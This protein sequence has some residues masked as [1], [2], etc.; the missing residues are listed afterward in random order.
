MTSVDRTL[1]L[2]AIAATTVGF[3][4]AALADCGSLPGHDALAKALQEAVKPSGGPRQ[5]RT[6]PQHVGELVDVDGAVCAV[7]FTGKAIAATSGPAAE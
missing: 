3:A 6:R 4:T 2:A 5:W 1:A 7:A